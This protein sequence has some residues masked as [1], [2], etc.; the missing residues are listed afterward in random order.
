VG[1]FKV[2]IEVG[3]PSGQR[4]EQYQA[5]VDTGSTYSV[6]PAKVLRRLGVEPHRR[7]AFELADGT[8]KEWPIGRT[9]LRLD[10]RQEVSL[11]V[12]GDEDSEPILGAL[13]L[14]EFLLAPDPVRR[15]LVPVPGLMMLFA[16]RPKFS[17]R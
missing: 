9:W 7:S 13:A 10:G 8:Q 3:D 11:V 14:E 17:H 16:S 12:F 2:D 15:R 1:T 5:L 6:F 4:F